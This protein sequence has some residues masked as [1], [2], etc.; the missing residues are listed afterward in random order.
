MINSIEDNFIVPLTL[1]AHRIAQKFYQ[2]LSNSGKAKQVYLNT[3]A[4]YAVNF[5]LEC[6][7]IE[8]ELTASNSWQP[9]MQLLSNIAD[10]EVK[11]LGKLEC[12]PM[13]PDLKV[14]Q[15]PPEVFSDRIGYVVVGLDAELTQ[16]TLLGFVPKITSEEL[17]LNQLKPL[18][19]LIEYISQKQPQI[20][21]NQWLN[22]LF[23]VGWETVE[24]MWE[25]LPALALNYRSPS[26]LKIT[27][28]ENLVSGVK[29]GKLL[30]L[31]RVEDKV[32]LCVRIKPINSS[33]MDISVEIYPVVGKI[34]LPQDLQLIVLDET[35]EA[36]MQAVAKGTKSMQLKFSGERGESFVIKVA[37]GNISITEAF[38][39]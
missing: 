35:G 11:N 31:S 4:V 17:P 15:I 24:A 26:Q 10:L 12:R 32:A 23:E 19:D 13:L 2:N 20:R 27:T 9:L 21:L 7:G 14:C 39:I 1:E 29:R 37:L 33:K 5:Y 6:L 22:Q 34:Y 25:Q 28:S 18:P 30:N 38:L 8:T 16:A 36:V 3:L